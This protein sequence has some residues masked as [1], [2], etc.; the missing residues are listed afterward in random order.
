MQLDL[1]YCTYTSN[2]EYEINIYEKSLEDNVKIQMY[3]KDQQL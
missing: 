3:F 2:E 1:I